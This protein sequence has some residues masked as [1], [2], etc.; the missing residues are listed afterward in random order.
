[1]FEEARCLPNV[2]ELHPP[3]VALQVW[4]ARIAVCVAEAVPVASGAWHDL[5]SV[6]VLER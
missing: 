3:N 4:W 5:L 6:K 1:M 2:Q